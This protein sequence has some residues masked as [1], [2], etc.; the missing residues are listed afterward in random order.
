MLQRLDNEASS[1]LQDYMAKE[2]IDYQLTPAGIRRRNS[3]ERG[4]QT[5][6]KHFIAGLC[7]TDPR[8][9]LNLW[10]KTLLHCLITLNLLRASRVNPQLS[11][12]AQIHGV[13]DYNRTPLTPPGI[14]VLAHIRPDDRR[15]FAPHAE[16]GCYF[17]LVMVHYR[18]HLIWFLATNLERIVQT[19]KWFPAYD[20][21]MPIASRDALVTTAAQEL[22]AA[23]KFTDH[24]SLLLTL[25]TVTRQNLQK[26]SD[27]FGAKNMDRTL[28]PV[29]ANTSAVNPASLPR[30]TAQP[31]TTQMKQLHPA[32]PPRVRTQTIPAQKDISHPVPLPRVIAPELIPN[33]RKQV[34]PITDPATMMYNSALYALITKSS[35]KKKIIAIEKRRSTRK[36]MQTK[37]TPSTQSNAQSPA[38]N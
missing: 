7:S 10:D 12:Y 27:I 26:F 37:N 3:F 35:Q 16:A 11:A 19:L 13:F 14:R 25:Q 6:K 17:C 28:A 36:K 18:C 29:Q 1:M 23:L 24:D 22:T 21:K 8:F 9:A 33:T 20:I 34:R 31:I 4:I 32:Q 30:V 5:I 15:L 2:G 38:T